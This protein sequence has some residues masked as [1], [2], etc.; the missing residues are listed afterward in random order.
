MREKKGRGRIIDAFLS[1]R[2]AGQKGHYSNLG[3]QN[4]V[5]WEQGTV[6]NNNFS[7]GHF[8]FEVAHSVGR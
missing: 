1:V 6:G 3:T 7:L 4:Q 2:A 5:I 8:D